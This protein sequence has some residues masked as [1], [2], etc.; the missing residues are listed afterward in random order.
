MVDDV[1]YTNLMTAYSGYNYTRG[2]LERNELGEYN[3]L[4][5]LTLSHNE[6]RKKLEE[7]SMEICSSLT[8][9]GDIR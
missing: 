1:L 6:Y 2:L 8:H 9:R 5:S 3:N 4:D 7:V